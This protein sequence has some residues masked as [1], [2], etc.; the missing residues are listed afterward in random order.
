L[1]RKFVKNWLAKCSLFLGEEAK[2]I[3]EKFAEK[4]TGKNFNFVSFSGTKIEKNC[5]VL[6]S[7]FSGQ[8]CFY[9][10][11]VCSKIGERKSASK[12]AGA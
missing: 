2:N 6:S 7:S 9:F 5:L 10:E 8:F 1:E 3:S 12:P 4:E 11:N